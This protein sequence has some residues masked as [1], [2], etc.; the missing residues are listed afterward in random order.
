MATRAVLAP[1]EGSKIVFGRAQPPTPLGELT[2]L[3]QLYVVKQIFKIS[4]SEYLKYT[5]KYAILTLNNQ[6]I[7]WGVLVIFF[8]LKSHIC[9]NVEILRYFEFDLS[10]I[11]A[12]VANFDFEK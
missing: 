7:F 11:T 10:S 1:S 5:R 12:A 4:A 2:S 3:L 6:N 8:S 9:Q